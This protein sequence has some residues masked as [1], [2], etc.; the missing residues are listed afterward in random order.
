MA[1]AIVACSAVAQAQRGG[2]TPI[3]CVNDW[4]RPDGCA[5]RKGTLN[6]RDRP[7]AS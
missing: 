5:P 4:Q 6:P 3:R 2:Q 7:A 1:A